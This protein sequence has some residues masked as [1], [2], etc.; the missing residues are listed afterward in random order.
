MKSTFLFLAI[1]LVAGI[2]KAQ[3]C[4]ALFSVEQNSTV[5]YFTNESNPIDSFTTFSWSF[6]DGNTSTLLNPW[7]TYSSIGQ[8]A[9]CLTMTNGFLGCSSTYCDT[10]QV[11][12][13][14][15]NATCEAAFTYSVSG[16]DVVFYNSSTCPL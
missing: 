12:T 4:Q 6:G 5:V 2:A 14:N 3:N 1:I 9:V 16:L 7:H 13:A 11:D 8:Y 10:I 15:S